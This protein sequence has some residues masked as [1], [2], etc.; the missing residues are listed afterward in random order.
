M[1]LIT[2]PVKCIQV[3]CLC[4][5]ICTT[6]RSQEEQEPEHVQHDIMEY[7][8]LIIHISADTIPIGDSARVT[9]EMSL[10]CTNHVT[11][12]ETV[13]DTTGD[14]Q[15][16]TLAVFG[17]FA[18]GPFRP[19]CAAKVVDQDFFI[20]FPRPGEWAIEG[21]QPGGDVAHAVIVVR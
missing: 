18:S 5:L 14:Y 21:G 9:L 11:R 8:F 10:D 6:G 3:V 20:H 2:I 7:T 16:V 17:T 1:P 12:F 15:K 4:F 13:F 19:L